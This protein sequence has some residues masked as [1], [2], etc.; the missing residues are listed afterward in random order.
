M[1][2]PVPTWERNN[3][4]YF[5]EENVEEILQYQVLVG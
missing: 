5:T 2:E 3:K 4:S 1:G